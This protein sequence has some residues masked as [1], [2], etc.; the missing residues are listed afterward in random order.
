[1]PHLKEP[2]NGDLY[3]KV[4]V[5]IPENLNENQ[6]KLLEEFAKIYDENPRTKIIV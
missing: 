1:M 4:K 5:V 3:A 6:R 2:G